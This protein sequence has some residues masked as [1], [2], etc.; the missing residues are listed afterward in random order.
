MRRSFTCSRQ[1]LPL[2][3][4]NWKRSSEPSTLTCGLRKRGQ[5]VALV[6]PGV[7]VVADA[8]QRGFQQMHDG[9]QHLLARQP[10]QR[11]VLGEPGA[12]RRQRP[13]ELHHVLVLRALAH[14]AEL[15]VIA[16][17]LAAPGVAAGGLDV[18]VGA[19]G[20]SR[21]RSRRAGWRACGC[22]PAW[23]RRRR[24]RRQPSDRRSPRPCARRWMPRCS[25]DTYTSPADSAASRGST[26]AG[27]CA[28]DSCMRGVSAASAKPSRRTSATLCYQLAAIESGEKRGSRVIVPRSTNSMSDILIAR[29][30]PLVRRSHAAFGSPSTWKSAPLSATY[31]P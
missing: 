9:G 10:A 23:P 6:R 27:A 19:W 12:D 20:R 7:V 14:F 22:A 13:R 17:L 25:S 30:W 31:R 21:R 26:M 15:R 2:L 5:A 29:I 1:V 8:D 4:L 24:A 3:P 16:V 28:C 11:H 18:A